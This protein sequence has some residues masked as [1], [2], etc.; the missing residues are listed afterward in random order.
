FDDWANKALDVQDT[1][2]IKRLL[3]A[4][5]ERFTETQKKDLSDATQMALRW[6][7]LTLTVL[8]GAGGKKP[9]EK[10]LTLVKRWFAEEGLDDKGLKAVIAKLTT[11]FKAITAALNRG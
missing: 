11:G 8:V 3:K 4:D 10:H 7:H 6:C 1:A 5:N 9:K 2:R